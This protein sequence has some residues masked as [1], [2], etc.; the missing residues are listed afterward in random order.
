VEHNFAPVHSP[1]SAGGT[2]ANVSY[3]VKSMDAV[4]GLSAK[5]HLRIEKP[6]IGFHVPTFEMRLAHTRGQ[7]QGYDLEENTHGIAQKYQ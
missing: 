4:P 6:T 1:S 3:L 7:P 2:D 5:L